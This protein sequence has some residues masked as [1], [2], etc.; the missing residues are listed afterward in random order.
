[1]VNMSFDRITAIN[2][3]DKLLFDG[4][5]SKLLAGTVVN[6]QQA[7]LHPNRSPKVQAPLFSH[8]RRIPDSFLGFEVFVSGE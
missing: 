1:M 3:Q 2:K 4:P 8:L 5:F 7:M 6:Q